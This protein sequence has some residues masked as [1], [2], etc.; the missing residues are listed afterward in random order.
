MVAERYGASYL[1]VSALLSVP[2]LCSAIAAPV[3]GKMSDRLGRKT[4]L[5]ASQCL[6]LAGYL[7][8]A[9]SH[10][11][12]WMF[13]ARIISGA[14]AG[15]VA[16]AQSY[17]A[18]VTPPNRR[19]QAFAL[20]GAVFGVGFIGGPIA[21]GMLLHHGLVM[22]F[23]VAAGLEVVNLI[24]TLTFIPALSPAAGAG[25]SL[26][27]ALA[28]SGRRDIRR[29]LAREFLFIFS[30]VFFLASMSLYLQRTIHYD[31]ARTSM[32]LALAGVLGVISLLGLVAPLSRRVGDRVVAQVGLMALTIAYA[33][34]AFVR[35]AGVFAAILGVW[36]IGAAMVQP[37]LMAR[38]S[39][40]TPRRERG[41]VMG[42][43][44]ALMSVAMIAAPLAGSSVV[45]A[46][47]ELFGVVPAC[48][49]L[50]ALWIGRAPLPPTR[51]A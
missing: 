28:V 8:L 43:A 7:L 33:A 50:L 37:T 24:L 26:A 2:A 21:A 38:L 5:L 23:L 10:S 20:F 1:T 39:R 32:L 31:A 48:S 49:A 17:L 14:G 42:I 18:D 29:L 27:S 12:L 15:N 16:A 25:T 3:W 46:R 45:A 35:S 6:S 4:I 40:R 47:S 11:L 22:P 30:V 13:I 41:A 19:D 36:A 9:F 34:V 51:D 44:D